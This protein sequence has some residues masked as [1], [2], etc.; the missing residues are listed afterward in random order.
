M[1]VTEPFQ[2]FVC[3]FGSL[4][5]K[6]VWIQGSLNDWP[7]N[8][9]YASHASMHSSKEKMLGKDAWLHER[10]AKRFRLRVSSIH[11]VR[12]FLF[13]CLNGWQVEFTWLF[14]LFIICNSCCIHLL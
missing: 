12:H 6:N 11:A 3:L 13:G 7:D 14:V 8:F 10:L 2:G 9:A 1:T 5:F 4:R